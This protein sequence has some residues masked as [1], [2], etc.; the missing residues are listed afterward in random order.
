MLYE[1]QMK[2]MKMI[3]ENIQD[4]FTYSHHFIKLNGAHELNRYSMATPC[5]L[6]CNSELFC[7]CN[8]YKW[9]ACHIYSTGFIPK[10]CRIG[11]NIFSHIFKSQMFT[12]N[13][14][15]IIYCICVH[16]T[17]AVQLERIHSGVH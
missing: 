8:S 5:S 11:H 6:V 10:T 2:I 15:S 14:N 16:T 3:S 4:S 17:P 7:F 1:L 13:I 9:T 12:E